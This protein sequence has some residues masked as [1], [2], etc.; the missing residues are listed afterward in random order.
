[1][2]LLFAVEEG[3]VDGDEEP[4][5]EEG[6][7]DGVDLLAEEGAQTDAG[8]VLDAVVEEREVEAEDV[9]R[10]RDVEREVGV[11]VEVVHE[12]GHREHPSVEGHLLE[13]PEPDFEGQR[14]DRQPVRQLVQ[15]LRQE[16]LEVRE[17]HAVA[18]LRLRLRGGGGQALPVAVAVALPVALVDGLH[19]LEHL[20]LRERPPTWLEMRFSL[21]RN[22]SIELKEMR[23]RSFSLRSTGSASR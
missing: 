8:V 13:H 16:L 21:A 6:L 10:L 1:M 15:V 14:A 2:L 7:L 18:L 4:A 17:R 22:T 19:E 11:L 9:Q 5:L 3:H 23:S 12:R 20:R